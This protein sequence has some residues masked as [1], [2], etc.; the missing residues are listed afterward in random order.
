MP[1]FRN[2]E[3]LTLAHE[4]YNFVPIC[5]LHF[6]YSLILLLLFLNF[7]S[8][9]VFVARFQIIASFAKVAATT[10]VIITGFYFLIF[11]GETE[12]LAKPFEG[13]NYSMGA[14]LAALFAGLYSYDGWD[15]LNFGAEEIEK[16][17]RTMPLSII[18]GMSLVVII[19]LC[20][21]L[22][23]FTVLDVNTMKAST[24]VASMFAKEKLGSFQLAIP[25]LISLLLIGSMNSTMF[26]A[27]RYLYAAARRGHLPTFISCLNPETDSP[28]AALIV[29]VILA[30]GISFLGDPASLI[31]Y[32]GFAMW[33]LRGFTIFALLWIRFRHIPVHPDAIKTPIIMPISFFIICTALISVT[34]V[35]NFSVAAF[36]V[37]IVIFGLIIYFTFIY[38]RALPSLSWFR[39]FR[40]C[41][42]DVTT[43]FVQIIL[44]VMPSQREESEQSSTTK[45]PI[46]EF[47]SKENG[48]CTTKK[49]LSGDSLCRRT[50]RVAPCH[51]SDNGPPPYSQTN[52]EKI[53]E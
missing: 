34:L 49:S 44:N 7:L 30:M 8:L 53:A 45:V 12:N 36:S 29:N 4:K 10:L 41:F 42:N 50:S 31:I 21:N 26:S 52:D 25:F 14:L 15:I 3:L 33:S 51:N 24:A 6:T 18:F 35:K 13:S 43:S 19:Y 37:V 38:D 40:F 23:Y 46:D 39:K 9:R 20:T 47:Y 11:K 48:T 32:V 28:R 1:E 2:F 27:S 17:K 16:P 5:L 22:A